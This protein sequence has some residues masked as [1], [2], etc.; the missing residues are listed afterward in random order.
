MGCQSNNYP[1]QGGL[2]GNITYTATTV[3]LQ[4]LLPSEGDTDGGE[5]TDTVDLFIAIINFRGAMNTAMA[6]SEPSCLFLLALAI[7][8]LS[9]AGARNWRN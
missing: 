8:C 4:N 2:F 9:V 1:D 5:D 3:Q 6:M 7:G